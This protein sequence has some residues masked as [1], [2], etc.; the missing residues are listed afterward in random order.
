MLKSDGR[1]LTIH[2]G[3]LPRTI[4]D[5]LTRIAEAL[6]DSSRLMAGTDCGFD[7]SAGNGRVAPD[8]V[9]AKLGALHAGA[10]RTSEQLF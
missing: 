3:S 1:I 2:T 7:I 9:W 4:A 10:E 5:C 8:V 6:G